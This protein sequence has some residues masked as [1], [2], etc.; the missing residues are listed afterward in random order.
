[1]WRSLV[2]FSSCSARVFLCFMLLL[3]QRLAQERHSLALALLVRVTKAP[4]DWVPEPSV[5]D[6]HTTAC[7]TRVRPMSC[8]GNADGQR[9]TRERHVLGFVEVVAVAVVGRR[10]RTTHWDGLVNRVV[11]RCAAAV[12]AAASATTVATTVVLVLES[13]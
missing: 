5:A 4:R 9:S 13:W 1:M 8:A 6:D 2:S 10:E 11:F 7:T 3:P 12:A